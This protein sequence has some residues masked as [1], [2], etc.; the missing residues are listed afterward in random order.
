MQVFL[1]TTLLKEPGPQRAFFPARGGAAA[2]GFP[3]RVASAGK[4]RLVSE[5]TLSGSLGSPSIFRWVWP[6]GSVL[7]WVRNPP[8]TASGL[9]LL[10]SS[11]EFIDFSGRFHVGLSSFSPFPRSP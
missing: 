7:G 8:K 10:V 4:T 3:H 11:P 6:F 9:F 1:K 2:R 5:N